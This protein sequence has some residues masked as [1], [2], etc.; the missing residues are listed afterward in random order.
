MRTSFKQ[1]DLPP[2]IGRVEI[3]QPNITSTTIIAC[4]D[5]ERVLVQ[6]IVF[7]RLHD[8]PHGAVNRP[9]HRC[10]N[11]QPMVLNMGERGIVRFQRLQ[12][13]MDAPMREIE[14]ERLIAIIL[15]HFHRLVRVIVGDVSTRLKSRSVIER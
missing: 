11:T 2:S 10:V 4:K 15:N 13:R 7:Q 5:D 6:A 14:K 3:I 12:R 9:G 1:G 8:A